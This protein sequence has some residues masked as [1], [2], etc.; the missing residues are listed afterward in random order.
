MV[1]ET[2]YYPK[3]LMRLLKLISQVLALVHSL[4][5][6]RLNSQNPSLLSLNFVVLVICQ[7]LL[8]T[9]SLVTGN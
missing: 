5:G 4:A 9:V 2:S 6:R 1:H 7:V 3:E 8:L